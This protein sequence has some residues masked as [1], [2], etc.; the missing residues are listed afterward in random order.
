MC[1]DTHG[2][3]DHIDLSC[4]DFSEYDVFIHAG[5]GTNVG[6]VDQIRDLNTFL[7]LIPIKNRI[8]IAGNHD[9]SFQTAAIL[10]E[11]L[12]TNATYL[13][14][15]SIVID[16]VKFYGSPW[17]PEFCGWAFMVSGPEK[18]AACWE[19]IPSDTNV[20]I[21]HGP[22]Y[23]YLDTVSPGSDNLGCKELAKRI[24]YLKDLK[25]HVFGHIHGGYGQVQDNL[26]RVNASVCDERYRPINPFISVTLDE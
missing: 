10:A 4:Y 22:A 8:C 13:R 14:D 19:Q 25:L 2:L 12:I 23:G 15:S 16:G 11:P 5:D 7:G 26:I 3:H 1:S 20:L 17:T 9:W 6:K 24:T 18:L 21:T